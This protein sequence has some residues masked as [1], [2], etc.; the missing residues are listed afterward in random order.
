MNLLVFIF[1]KLIL[2]VYPFF[3]RVFIF[4]ILIRKSPLNVKKTISSFS[5]MHYKYFSLVCGL[6]FEIAYGMFFSWKFKMCLQ[7]NL[8]VFS[9]IDFRFGAVS[10]MTFSTPIIWKTNHLCVFLIHSKVFILHIFFLFSGIY[11]CIS[12]LVLFFPKW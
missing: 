1:W 7:S 10:R 3:I 5:D 4:F 11:L 6:F 12:D 8:W 9:V 2:H